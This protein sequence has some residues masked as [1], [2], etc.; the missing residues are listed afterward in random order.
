VR[1]VLIID[2]SKA[3]RDALQAA[4]DPYGLETEAADSGPRGLSQ[5]L[6]GRWDLIF[7]PVGARSTSRRVG[8]TIHL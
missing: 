1:R 8:G 6:T 3:M 4:L 2:D 7:D 5:A